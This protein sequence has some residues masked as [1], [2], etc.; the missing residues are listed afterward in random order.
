[1]TF[2][3]LCGVAVLIRFKTKRKFV[4]HDGFLVFLSA[5]SF[6]MSVFWIWL[7]AGIM[8]DLL[9]VLGLLTGLPTTLLGLTVLAWGNSIGDLMANTSIAKKGYV[10]MALTGC[11][12][13]PLFNILLGLGISTLRSNLQL[14]DGVRFSYQDRDSHIPLVL[15]IGSFVGLAFTFITTAF[16]N[17]GR[18][19]KSQAKVNL[20]IYGVILFVAVF[21]ARSGLNA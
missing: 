17:K 6:V 11:Y 1:M 9:K 18:I 2:L 7:F 20:V 10:E 14:E 4:P 13:S 21:M 15:I 3:I 12:A 16:I 5:I 19:T 8:I